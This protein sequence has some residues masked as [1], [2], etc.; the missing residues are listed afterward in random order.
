MY[1]FGISKIIKTRKPEAELQGLVLVY[2][3]RTTINRIHNINNNRQ[4]S[5]AFGILH[6]TVLNSVNTK[7]EMAKILDLCFLYIL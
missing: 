6:I 4:T 5:G 7:S 2:F 1:G 3:G